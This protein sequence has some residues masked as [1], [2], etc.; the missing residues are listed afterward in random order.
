MTL[1]YGIEISIIISLLA[2]RFTPIWYNLNEFGVKGAK[3]W[4]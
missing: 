4:L 3:I 1:F 2:K